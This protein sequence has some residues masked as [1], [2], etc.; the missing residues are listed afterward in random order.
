M[1]QF[2]IF[3]I[4]NIFNNESLD[5]EIITQLVGQLDDTD[6]N[7]TI[8]ATDDSTLIGSIGL[9]ICT[10]YEI[11]TNT[12]CISG[13]MSNCNSHSILALNLNIEKYTTSTPENNKTCKIEKMMISLLALIFQNL[14]NLIY[15]H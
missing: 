5:E 9:S 7:K 14:P 13:R 4:V 12:K 2:R 1:I 11:N 15:L 8:V 6:V 10:Y 3:F